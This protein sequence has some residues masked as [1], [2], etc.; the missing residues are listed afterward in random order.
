MIPVSGRATIYDVAERAGVS[1]A[2]VSRALNDRG[3]SVVRTK[4]R[5]CIGDKRDVERCRRDQVVSLKMHTEREFADPVLRD[6]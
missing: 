5:E 3:D 4:N 2:T 1:I 6:I